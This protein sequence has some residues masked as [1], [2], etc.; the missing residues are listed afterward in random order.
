MRSGDPPFPKRWKSGSASRFRCSGAAAVHRPQPSFRGGARTEAVRI[1]TEDARRPFDLS[2][3]PLFRVHLVRCAE[4]YHRVYLTVHHLVFDGVSIYRVLIRELAALYSAYAA[5][6]PSPLPELAV[7]Y[8]DYAAVEATAAGQRQSC[9][10]NEILA[11]DSLGEPAV[12]RAPYRPA[13][14]RAEPTWRGGME[15]CTIPA[16]LLEALK[17]LGRSEGADALHDAS[18]RVPGSAVSLFR[19]RAKSSWAARRIR[20]PGPSSSH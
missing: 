3:A 18:G 19:T 4:D 7:Q 13:A 12:V 10:R 2:V 16:Q 1:A 6:Q 5:G 9:R 15:T 14:S 20:A 11:R 17:E 8:G